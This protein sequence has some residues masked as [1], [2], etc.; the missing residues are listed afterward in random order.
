MKILVTGSSGFIGTAL[1]KKLLKSGHKVIGMD[2][3]PCNK[4]FVIDT[5][6]QN[7]PYDFTDGTLIQHLIDT[8][9]FD[10]DVCFHVGAIADVTTIPKYDIMQVIRTNTFGTSL[11]AYLC[12]KKKISMNYVSTC[13]VYG[14]TN[15]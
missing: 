12:S 3:A 2:F 11:I 8:K 6:F 10:P 9:D 13:C 7:Y 5:K 14:D 15:E 1:V 4:D